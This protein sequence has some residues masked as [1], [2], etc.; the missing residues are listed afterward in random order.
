MVYHVY[1]P[2]LEIASCQLCEKQCGLYQMVAMVFFMAQEVV[3]LP[4]KVAMVHSY[5]SL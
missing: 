3:V 2:W 5:A 1:G 4:T